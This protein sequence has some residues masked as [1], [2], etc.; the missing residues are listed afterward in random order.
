[1]GSKLINRRQANKDAAS[2]PTALPQRLGDGFFF[3]AK[4]K[5]LHR[6]DSFCVAVVNKILGAWRPALISLTMQRAAAIVRRRIWSITL[7]TRFRCRMAG[8]RYDVHSSLKE[9]GRAVVIAR[10]LSSGSRIIPGDW[11]KVGPGWLAR[12]L[13]SR[14]ASSGGGGRIHQF[15][16]HVRACQLREK[17]TWR[18]GTIRNRSESDQVAQAG[19]EPE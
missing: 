15:L 17:G 12:P 3:L 18:S 6:P 1:M 8:L 14:R 5:L 10:T 11:G 4:L 16:W 9:L 13:S 7:W 2:C 19:F